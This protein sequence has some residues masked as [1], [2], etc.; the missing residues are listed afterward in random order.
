MSSSTS[1]SLSNIQPTTLTRPSLQICQHHHHQHHPHHHQQHYCHQSSWGQLGGG[2]N[3]Y[4]LRPQQHSN[5]LQSN[6]NTFVSLRNK[7]SP[8]KIVFVDDILRL[9]RNEH[10]MIKVYRN[11][12]CFSTRTFP[13]GFDSLKLALI[14]GAS[15]VG[16][17]FRLRRIELWTSRWVVVL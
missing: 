13:V 11:E 10:V 6:F 5:N 12:K 15:K 1:S 9:C 8:K 2:D 7:Y 3:F 14:I 16:H 17:M 4:N